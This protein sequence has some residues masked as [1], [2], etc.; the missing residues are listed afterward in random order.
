VFPAILFAVAFAGP[1]VAQG[2]PRLTRLDPA[3]RSEVAR[4]VD[5]LRAV[6]VPAEP[7]V[8][9]A[10][11]GQA[12][13]ADG[14]RIASAVR[15][16]GA[17]LASARTALGP[18]TSDAALVAGASAIRNGV[19]AAALTQI[20]AARAQGG[21]LV[22]LAVLSELTAAGVPV[23]TAVAAILNVARTGGTDE[24]FRGLQRGL[25][26]G[27]NGGADGM[28]QGAGG[29]RGAA[30]PPAGMPGQGPGRGRGRGRP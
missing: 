30:G 20:G 21:S 15:N 19:S 2:D 27:H 10:L 23:D 8:V 16:W 25:G 9:K 26:R 6:G 5:S 7:L 4:L 18:A 12:K 3:T 11:E 14:P 28:P 17:D 29:R 22:P 13:G 24:D 1:A